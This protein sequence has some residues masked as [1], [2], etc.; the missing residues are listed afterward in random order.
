MSTTSFNDR[1]ENTHQVEFEAPNS[2]E[3]QPL[4][5]KERKHFSIDLSLEL[6][7]QLNMESPPVTPH[8]YPYTAALDTPEHKHEALDPEVLAHL[9][10]QLRQSLGE[11]TRERDD[12][13]KLLAA[14][15]SKEANLTD[16]LQLMTE[17]ATE[18][19][20]ELESARKKIKEDEEAISLLRA[21]VEESRYVT[22]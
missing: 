9:V 20:E 12:L 6:E 11:M 10:S 4:N 14:A 5:H 18:S 13:A 8:R 21:K 7:H 17:K 3:V 16:A 22:N 15:H 1:A 2:A 19:G